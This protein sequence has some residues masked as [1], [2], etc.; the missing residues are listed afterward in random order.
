MSSDPNHHCVGLEANPKCRNQVRKSMKKVTPLWVDDSLHRARRDRWCVVTMVFAL[1]VSGG[2]A[3]IPPNLPT[4]RGNP[5]SVVDAFPS[6]LLAEPLQLRAGYV[7]T[8]R[9][10]QITRPNERWAVS[11]GFIRNDQS[12]PLDEKL[13]G[14]SNT[15]WIDT[16]RPP[17][18][19]RVVSPG[20]KVQW[21]LMK[22]DGRIVARH[23]LDSAYQESGGTYSAVAITRTLPGFSDQPLG[24]YRL[25][26]SV[27]RDA[28]ELEFL[29]PHILVGRPFFSPRSIE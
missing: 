22:E 7:H 17:K 3:S 4:V 15:C 19:C 23:A 29:N 10:F 2:C 20:F 8:T 18:F 5:V 25:R 13:R 6:A 14:A 9:P 11:L 27:V 1:C 12:V 24:Q 26:I 21:E 16:V 28:K